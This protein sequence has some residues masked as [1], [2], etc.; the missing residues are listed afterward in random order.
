IVIG[1]ALLMGAAFALRMGWVKA[2]GHHH[3]PSVSAAASSSPAGEVNRAGNLTNV[4]SHLVQTKMPGG[5]QNK[6]TTNETASRPETGHL[7][8]G[9]LRV[10]EN[11]KEIFRMPPSGADATA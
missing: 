5:G 10:Y 1:M 6:A 4:G 11:G 3:V 8:E 9:S 7:P 2:S